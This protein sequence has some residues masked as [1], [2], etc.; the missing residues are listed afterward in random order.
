MSCVRT[1]QS[2]LDKAKW[3]LYSNS[4]IVRETE[5]NATLKS[6]E[7]A[8]QGDFISLDKSSYSGLYG[9]IKKK[10]T[11]KIE[12]R[13]CDGFAF[14]CPEKDGNVSPQII[15][16]TELKSASYPGHF[17]LA[18]RQIVYTYF[19]IHNVLSLCKGY[20]CLGHTF[21]GVIVCR[22]P[23]S[24]YITEADAR[25][26]ICIT[27]AP[28]IQFIDRMYKACLRHTGITIPLDGGGHVFKNLSLDPD[29]KQQ[30]LHLYL[31]LTEA[32]DDTHSTLDLH[33]VL[34]GIRP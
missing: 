7:I 32:S 25:E 30:K 9:A 19:K 3:D 15:V 22:P 28:D 16:A 1:Y 24:Q 5:S 21:V 14:L 4:W 31:H 13:D 6:L 17:M 8:F 11:S 12:D 18:Y 10:M 29:F 27:E 20:S 26:K 33:N 23:E 2:F 34:K